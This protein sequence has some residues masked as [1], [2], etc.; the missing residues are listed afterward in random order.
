MG[1]PG[2]VTT[3]I[4]RGA[5]TTPLADV[6]VAH[7][8]YPRI[9]PEQ[10]PASH[11][12]PHRAVPHTEAAQLAERDHAV[13]SLREQCNPRVDRSWLFVPHEDEKPGGHEFLPHRAA[14]V[15]ALG[16]LPEVAGEHAQGPDLPV[17]CQPPE[18]RGGS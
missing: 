9:E 11:P 4:E 14:P 3:R 10:A 2:V 15:S 13:I 6:R 8:E 18:L 12:V 17:L 1:D 7:G 16:E 5:P